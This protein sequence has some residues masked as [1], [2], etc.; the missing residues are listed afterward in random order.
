METNYR[1]LT[2]MLT[3]L[4]P[5]ALVAAAAGGCGADGAAPVAPSATV[6]AA[7]AHA[8]AAAQQPAAAQPGAGASA[9]AKSMRRV[10]RLA[11]SVSGFALI[12]PKGGTLEIRSVGLKLVVPSGAV[13]RPTLFRAT[14][15]A[16]DVVAYDF[17]P[18][19]MR[20]GAPLRV[21]QRVRETEWRDRRDAAP[22]VAGYFKDARQLDARRHTALV[23]EVL[24]A[25]YDV[26]GGTLRFEVEHFSGYMVSTGLLDAQGP[27]PSQ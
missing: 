9:L 19:G 10:R 17:A 21:E 23:D 14:A 7:A 13:T 6:G 1:M 4:A 20:F 18:H 2:R 25:T 11:G 15:L 27:A 16:G 26:R 24:P 12:G 22:C 5:L 8:L 3:R